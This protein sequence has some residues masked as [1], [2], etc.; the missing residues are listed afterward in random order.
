MELDYD[1][2]SRAEVDMNVVKLDN[3]L[4]EVQG[5]GEEGT[6][7]RDQLNEMLDAADDGINKIFQ[8]Q[9]NILKS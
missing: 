2:D 3:T 7:T 9:R 1:H 8:A 4:V 5:T 6:F